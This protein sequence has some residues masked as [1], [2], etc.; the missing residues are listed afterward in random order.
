[1]RINLPSVRGGSEELKRILDDHN[2][3]CTLHIT[4]TLHTL[5]SHAKDLVAS[6]QRNNVVYKYDYKDCEAVYFGESK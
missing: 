4:T 3:N 6:E 2:I 5:L 1:M